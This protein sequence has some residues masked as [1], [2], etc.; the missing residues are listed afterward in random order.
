MQPK[1]KKLLKQIVKY[2][3]TAP[4]SE[5]NA[6]WHILTALRGPDSGKDDQKEA[7]TC[8][9]RHALGLKKHSIINPD[10]T[11]R[12]KFRRDDVNLPYD[13]PNKLQWHFKDH[14]LGAFAALNLD[15]NKSNA[16]ATKT[17]RP[18]K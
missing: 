8:V 7:T 1:T 5:A 14:A 9:I 13:N 17:K 10:S 12:A 16:R 18:C 2:I 3:N 11:S 4:Y 15:W 6:L